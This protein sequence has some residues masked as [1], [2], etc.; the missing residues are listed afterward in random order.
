MTK[1]AVVYTPKYLNHNPGPSHPESAKRLKVI[2]EALKSS[3]IIDGEKCK[4]FEP[5]AARVKDVELVH[6]PD[7]IE[8]VNRVSSS[9]GGLLDQGD[10]EL[11]PGSFEVALYAVG[12]ALKAV[13]LVLVKKVENAF[14]FVRPPGHHAGLYTGAGFC[15]FNNI[16]IAAT[17]LLRNFNFDR[18]LILDIDAHHGNGTQEIFYDTDKVLFISLHQD[19][20]GFPGAGFVDE[21]G[22]R[23]GLGYKV[24]FP[25]PYGTP[26]EP[27]EKAFEEVITPIVEQ[28]QPQFILVSAGFDG[29]Y[30]DPVGGL[31]LTVNG[32]MQSFQRILG[33]AAKLCD[34]KLVAVLEGGYSLKIVG[35]IATGAVAQM[36]GLPFSFA[37]ESPKI[38][39]KTV[40]QA[41]KIIEEVKRIHSEFWKLC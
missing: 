20:R 7:Y 36:A 29:H 25:F 3:H 17:H 19:P 2:M 24:N 12:G 40:K 22:E 41:E 37:E 15:I 39:S 18:V 30:S 11:S 13:D 38:D 14:A 9:G 5:D 28:Y 32:Y 27:Y 4:L 21:I 1:T 34:R 35:K 16:A 10:T 26:D 6:H 8:L 31:A 33:Y 23:D